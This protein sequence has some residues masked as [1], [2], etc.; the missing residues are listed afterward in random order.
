MSYEW[1]WEGMAF[2]WEGWIGLSP[3]KN[4]ISESRAIILVIYYIVREF[5]DLVRH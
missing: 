5:R 1:K 4:I 2:N 3:R